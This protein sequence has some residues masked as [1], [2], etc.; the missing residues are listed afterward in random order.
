MNT[1]E[2]ERAA[3]SQRSLQQDRKNKKIV[4]KNLFP[5]C[6]SANENFCLLRLFFYCAKQKHS[7]IKFTKDIK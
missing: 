2:N 6:N 5:R 7:W 3:W 1:F 4:K